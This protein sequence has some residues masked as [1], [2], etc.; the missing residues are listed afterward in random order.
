MGEDMAF[1]MNCGQRINDDE[2]FCINCGAPVAPDPNA[3]NATSAGVGAP[4]LAP[5]PPALLAPPALITPSNTA[6]AATGKAATARK[7]RLWLI[8]VAV[9][10]TVA[11]ALGI[12]V[13]HNI[14]SG[15]PGKVN[16][17]MSA[18]A[19]GD[20]E[21]ASAL[22]GDYDLHGNDA[23]IALNDKRAL[24][25]EPPRLM[26]GYGIDGVSGT[27]TRVH[28]D[29]DNPETTGPSH[30]ADTLYADNPTLPDEAVDAFSNDWRISGLAVTFQI[31]LPTEAKSLAINGTNVAIPDDSASPCTWGITSED[32]A[33]LGIRV[34]GNYKKCT[35]LGWPGVYAL[36]SDGLLS[37]NEYNFTVAGESDLN[38]GRVAFI[39]G[40]DSG[41]DSG[42]GADR[43]PTGSGS[44]GI[45]S[46]K[47]DAGALESIADRYSSRDV[48][49]S[50]TF[51]GS[52]GAAATPDSAVANTTAARTK[53]VSAGLYLPVYLAARSNGGNALTKAQGMMQTMSNDDAN[54]AVTDL[55][56]FD[57]INNWLSQHGYADTTLNRDFGD[58]QASDAGHENYSSTYDAVRMLAAVDAAGA[59]NLMNVDIVSE[60]VSI[61]T[62]MTVHAH[63]GQ[64]IKDTWNYFAVV[65][66]QHGKAAVAL[67]TQN[68][69]KATAARIMSDVLAD[70]DQQLAKTDK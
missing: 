57:A 62:G 56:G 15:F 61:P 50:A 8:P 28:Y 53:F 40:L 63:R 46:S 48:A 58:V 10:V 59:A 34:P 33:N 44:S 3:P 14:Y 69:G 26:K 55:G 38:A 35:F 68:Q 65:T 29:V 19:T 41:S 52:N 31:I 37:G 23:V 11:V 16:E 13:A 42:F 25:T 6:V 60:G 1:C 24:P 4:A 2:R 36:D 22:A 21:R 45:S 67:A 20:Y 9:V 12:L 39:R 32:M 47:P 17:Y 27:G 5:T 70:I 30:N 49:V 51:L 43:S 54:Q 7:R 66:T 18:V 64:G